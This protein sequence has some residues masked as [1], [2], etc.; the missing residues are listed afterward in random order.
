[1]R[2]T[3]LRDPDFTSA[4]LA[5]FGCHID[6]RSKPAAPIGVRKPRDSLGWLHVVLLM[7]DPPAVESERNLHGRT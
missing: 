6:A 3:M 4:Y 7:A 2:A 1:M 5:G